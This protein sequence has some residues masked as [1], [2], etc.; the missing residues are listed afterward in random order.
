MNSEQAAYTDDDVPRSRLDLTAASVKNMTSQLHRSDAREMLV[1]IA[2]DVRKTEVKCSTFSK[3]YERNSVL[4]FSLLCTRDQE[5]F[6]SLLAVFLSRLSA[7][8]VC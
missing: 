6:R 2:R 3:L 5:R 1:V 8:S 7:F 4:P